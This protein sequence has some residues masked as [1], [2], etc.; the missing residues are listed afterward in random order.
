M[1]YR[2]QS[3]L[4]RASLALT[5]ASAPLMAQATGAKASPMHAEIEKRVSTVM[6]QV[7]AWRRDI[8]EHPELSGDEVRTSKLV[9]EALKSMGIEVR[10]EVG[11]HG[12]VGVLK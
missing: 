3:I 12:V 6:P 11:G 4:T 7:I 9:A 8:H 10:A 5:V 2:L 1:T